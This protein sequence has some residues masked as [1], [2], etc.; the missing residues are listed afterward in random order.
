[1][2]PFV[3]F[4]WHA[5]LPLPLRDF[6]AITGREKPGVS[7]RIPALLA[8]ISILKLLEM[9][10]LIQ[11]TGVSRVH[12][13]GLKRDGLGGTFLVA[14]ST[15]CGFPVLGEG[16]QVRLSHLLQNRSGVLHRFLRR[17]SGLELDWRAS[18]GRYARVSLP[19]RARRASGD[20]PAHLSAK[21]HL[22][23]TDLHLMASLRCMLLTP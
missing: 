7:R 21:R 5:T 12:H 1:L 14:P 16:T 8:D 17:R 15:L 3:P 11:R 9:T 19:R 13:A 22:L 23:E 20:A 4:S 2:C 6:Q 18:Q 10:L